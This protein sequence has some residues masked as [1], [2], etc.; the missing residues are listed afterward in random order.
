MWLKSNPDSN[1]GLSLASPPNL[2]YPRPQRIS[3]PQ[4]GR[5]YPYP[6]RRHQSIEAIH[7]YLP[8]WIP[9]TSTLLITLTRVTCRTI[10]HLSGRLSPALRPPKQ[11]FSPP[12]STIDSAPTYTARNPLPNNP[13]QQYLSIST[14]RGGIQQSRY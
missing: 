9:P 11:P 4:R 2:W 13:H 10:A 6:Y 3:H 7:N 1:S 14:A 5:P 12:A 8:Q